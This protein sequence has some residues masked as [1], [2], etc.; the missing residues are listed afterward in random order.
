VE[1][2]DARGVATLGTSVDPIDAAFDFGQALKPRA[3]EYV[4]RWSE[5]VKRL[6]AHLPIIP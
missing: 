5:L 1:P 4:K 3:S 6:A 2:L